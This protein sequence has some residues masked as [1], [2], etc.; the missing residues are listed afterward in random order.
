MDYFIYDLHS[1]KLED[2]EWAVKSLTKAPLEREKNLNV[3]SSVLS[4][5]GNPHYIVED[6]PEEENLGEIN[7]IEEKEK[8]NHVDSNILD[9]SIDDKDKGNLSAVE[10]HE[11]N[12]NLIDEIDERDFKNE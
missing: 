1:G 8:S 6:K 11:N 12:H 3:I 2:L 9:C 10:E 7:D 4:W 5:G